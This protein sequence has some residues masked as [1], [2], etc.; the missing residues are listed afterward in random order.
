VAARV[1][2]WKREVED[3]VA[4]L[5]CLTKSSGRKRASTAATEECEV[6]RRGQ[7]K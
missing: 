1:G 7:A 2:E 4:E 3:E 5:G 6:F